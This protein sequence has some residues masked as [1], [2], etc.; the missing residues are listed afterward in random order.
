MHFYFFICALPCGDVKLELTDGTKEDQ[1]EVAKKLSGKPYVILDLTKLD[2][3]FPEADTQ[4][5]KNI[6][7]FYRAAPLSYHYK[8]RMDLPLVTADEWTFS[9]IHKDLIES[10][11]E[12]EGY[13]RWG[14]ISDSD[15]YDFFGRSYSEYHLFYK[16]E[17]SGL[18][19]YLQ[20][21][22]ERVLS[23]GTSLAFKSPLAQFAL[24]CY[25]THRYWAD[26]THSGLM[27]YTPKRGKKKDRNVKKAYI[28]KPS[29]LA[30]CHWLDMIR[31]RNVL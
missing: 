9:S 29:H 1:K 12:P 19:T 31:G 4:Q 28:F 20:P 15:M 6:Q 25:F 7:N 17:V 3:G 16:G 27:A 30:Q 11:N 8:V 13:K 10:L 5:E 23:A 22:L 21:F 2:Y 18:S 24:W 14:Q 26:T